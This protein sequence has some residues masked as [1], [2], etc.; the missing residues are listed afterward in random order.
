M[1][2]MIWMG[3]IKFINEVNPD[4][5]GMQEVDRNWSSSSLFQ[6]IPTELANRL[7][8]Y[9][10]YSVSLERNN[11]Y[12]G[13]LILS[14]YP[15]VQLWSEQLAGSLERRSMVLTQLIINGVRVNFI[16]THLGL[17]ES[18]RVQQ[19]AGIMRLTRELK[20]PVLISG[21]FNGGGQDPA[22]EMLNTSFTNLFT[23]EPGFGGGT[24]RSKSGAIGAQA[25]DYIFAS[26]ELSLKRIQV[27]DN[28]ISDHLPILA[29]VELPLNPTDLSGDQ[30]YY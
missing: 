28:Y 30:L 29:E 10:A 9:Q 2:S 13:N 11:G 20:G 15:I 12:Y 26:P 14:K 1:A 24:F 16:T 22:V 7:Q 3:I 21:D 27:F 5:I 6:D 23:L 25:I 8:M 17:S 18:D 4:I 19:V